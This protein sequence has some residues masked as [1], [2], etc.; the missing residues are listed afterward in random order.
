M[1]HAGGD[2]PKKQRLEPRVPPGTKDQG[3]GLLLFAKV[4]QGSPDV[5]AGLDSAAR[6]LQ[7]CRPSTARSFLRHQLGLT[8]GVA[9][10]LFQGFPNYVSGH[11]NRRGGR[12]LAQRVPNA[13]NLGVAARKEPTGCL[14]R[15]LGTV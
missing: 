12:G 5:T 4:Y 2:A 10:Q 1:H 8:F 9:I 6:C 13:D 15:C 14:D 7:A 3:G 11:R